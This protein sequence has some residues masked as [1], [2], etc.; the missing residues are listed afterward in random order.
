MTPQD[1]GWLLKNGL[2][3][4]V[5]VTG[6]GVHG[7]RFEPSASVALVRGDWV[8]DWALDKPLQARVCVTTSP[9]PPDLPWAL[10]RMVPSPKPELPR[11]SYAAD[12]VPMSPAERHLLAVLFMHEFTAA[13]AP[14][15]LCAAAGARLGL[16]SSDV[17]NR[18]NVV[19]RRVN[20]RRQATIDSLDELGFYLVH[21]AQ[22]LSPDD[23][24]P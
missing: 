20:G 3:T 15:N 7:L 1:F 21:T 8:L 17:K 22:A 18:A 16:S 10:D 5:E 9:A 13:P 2:S 23:L 11:T 19:R 14:R 4:R 12:D 6:P 24:E